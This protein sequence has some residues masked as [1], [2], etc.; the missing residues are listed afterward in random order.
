[1]TL[2]KDAEGDVDQPEPRRLSRYRG[3]PSSKFAVSILIGMAL[4][5]VF[6]DLLSPYGP[7][8]IAAVPLQG[9]SSAHW[10]GT[11]EVGRDI[12]SRVIHASRVSMGIGAAAAL[13][14][15]VV[16]APWGI[17]AGY[18]GR[19]FDSISMRLIDG[20]LAFP[21]VL[22]AL[23]I[24]AALGQ[25]VLNL[26]IAL[27]ISQVAQFARLLRG[28]VLS[29]R[30]RDF[31]KSARVVGASEARILTRAIVPAVI[32]LTLVQF[33]L[34]FAAS[35]L[36]E[37]GLSFIGLGIRAPDPSW[38]N[39][40]SAAK[41]YLDFSWVYGI[42]PGLAIFLLV[43]ALGIAGDELTDRLERRTRA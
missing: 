3:S 26:I 25:S 2:R 12:L 24:I 39:M 16:G 27:A 33:S 1:M 31:V 34:S 36:S 7:R 13:T 41:R 40:L 20:I 10:L 43:L 5:A 11:D 18:R 32:P 4:V 6:A 30:E 14:A 19:W 21:G 15:L 23:T 8:E 35:V 38:G 37:T 29:V 9:V 42:A 22:L 28:E 17:I